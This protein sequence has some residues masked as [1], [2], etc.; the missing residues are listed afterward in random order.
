MYSQGLRDYQRANADLCV[1]QSLLCS[2]TRNSLR[3]G[4]LV[5]IYVECMDGW[6]HTGMDA[7]W[8]DLRRKI[9]S[10]ADMGL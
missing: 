3:P 4:A 5:D 2:S 9:N 1:L 6:M 7:W 8:I 10:V